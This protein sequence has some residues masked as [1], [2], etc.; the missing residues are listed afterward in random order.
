MES[1]K[2]K[3]EEC[4]KEPIH[5]LGKVQSHGVLIGIDTET[6]LIAHVSENV[7]EHLGRSPE[8]MFGQKLSKFFLNASHDSLLAALDTPAYLFNNPFR[9]EV[10]VGGKVAVF[11]AVVH[12]SGSFLVVELEPVQKRAEGVDDYFRLT[13]NTLLSLETG[14]DVLDVATGM[15][16]DIREYT[17]FDRVMIYRFD[18]E[19]NGEVIAEERDESRE[20]YFGLHFPASDIPVQARELYKRSWIRLIR[21]TADEP[22]PIESAKCPGEGEG[23]LDLSLSVLRAVSPVHIQYLKNMGVRCSMSIS[24]LDPA[25][26]LWGL[27]ACHHYSPRFFSYAARA[28]CVHY[29]QVLSTRLASAE[30]HSLMAERVVRRE[31]LSGTIRR[32]V[33]GEEIQE[34]IVKH[35][36]QFLELFHAD[37]IAVIESG[38]VETAGSTPPAKEVLEIGEKISEKLGVEEI[39]LGLWSTNFMEGEGL[40]NDDSAGVLSLKIGSDWQ[41]L[42]F[43][44]ETVSE[45]NWGGDSSK[46]KR[47]ENTGRL[48]PRDSFAAFKEVI[49]DKSRKW[50]ETD[51][52]IAGEIRSALAAFVIE[53][54]RRLT[55]LNRELLNRNTE[56]QQFAYSVSHD[57]KSPLVTVNGFV[58]ATVE[59]LDDGDLDQARHSLSRINAAVE[60]MGILINDLLEFS[61]IGREGSILE[62]IDMEPLFESLKEEFAGRYEEKGIELLMPENPLQVFGAKTDITRVFRNLLENAAKYMPEDTELPS[63]SVACSSGKKSVIYKVTDNGGGIP[64]RH[65]DRIFRLFERL[66]N[67]RHGTGVGLATVKKVIEQIGGG[68]EIISSEGAGSCFVLTFPKQKTD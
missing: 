56:L 43:R 57:L 31:N 27:I 47:D 55:D 58:R 67:S 38:W 35:S 54:S 42:V 2:E 26:E 44:D 15:A 66:D 33:T 12:R 62:I 23:V 46:V 9:F 21:D 6:G 50:S 51:L 29:G 68:V 7:S 48:S 22:S 17:G 18:G 59:D 20:S 28:A 24:L 30:Q 32:L 36:D 34:T 8:E 25:G 13:A 4:A 41:I 61:K 16:R 64:E 10:E 39:A 5:L 40:E 19:W 3:L 37:G 53:R 49:K 65:H 11:D 63:V 52:V 45:I 1:L 14:N 60:K